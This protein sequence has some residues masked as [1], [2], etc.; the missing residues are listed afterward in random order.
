MAQSDAR[1]RITLISTPFED[2]ARRVAAAADRMAG[3]V[4]V[5]FAVAG[6]A[7]LAAFGAASIGAIARS[8]NEVLKFGEEMENAGKKAGITA[9][10][11][12]L[13]NSAIS[14]GISTKTASKLIG[15][16]AKELD[17]SAGT[18]RDVSIKLWAVGEK[19]KGFWLGLMGRVAPIVSKLL[20]SAIGVNL[21]KAGQQFG[22]ALAKAVKIVYG[23]AKNGQLWE[24]IALGF[25]LAF[26]Y[27]KE[28]LLEFVEA[29]KT[30]L[31]KGLEGSIVQG[32]D[33][34]WQTMSKWALDASMWLS[35]CIYDGLEAIVT[36]LSDSWADVSQWFSDFSKFLSEA[37]LDGI[38]EGIKLGITL[39]EKLASVAKEL[40]A[41]IFGESVNASPV[42]VSAIA[43]AGQKAINATPSTTTAPKQPA[44]NEAGYRG[45]IPAIN[46][47][48]HTP[49]WPNPAKWFYH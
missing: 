2:G 9:G 23:L 38:A 33:I 32:L 4:K 46:L 27:G 20:D 25:Q 42:N 5:A 3:T 44:Q 12:Y 28:V 10:K 6:A 21:V 34:A 36:G 18:F 35:E 30:D 13:L 45:K 26:E 1:A 8:A 37:V 22:D 17:K 49:N 16:N 7:V 43:A 31:S 41:G 14:K 48:P 29:I 47:P 19:I 24:T 15:D 11:Y 39:F 40:L